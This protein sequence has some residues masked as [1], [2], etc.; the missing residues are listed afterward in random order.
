MLRPLDCCAQPP[1]LPEEAVNWRNAVRSQTRRE[2]KWSRASKGAR[3][4]SRNR[5]SNKYADDHGAMTRQCIRIPSCRSESLQSRCHFAICQSLL[6][7]TVKLTPPARRPPP[8]RKERRRSR[9]R[10]RSTRKTFVTLPLVRLIALPIIARVIKVRAF[11]DNDGGAAFPVRP[12]PSFAC[13]A[14][15]GAGAI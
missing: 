12:K 2:A 9:V 6:L 15:A 3:W 7:V 4:R 1:K 8:P 11:R 13:P 10:G 14:G 5:Y